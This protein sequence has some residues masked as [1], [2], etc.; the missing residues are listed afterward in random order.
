MNKKELQ[1]IVNEL[2]KLMREAALDLNFEQ[3]AVFRDRI[4]EIK[5]YIK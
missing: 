2:T 3:A 1:K 4:S 5:K